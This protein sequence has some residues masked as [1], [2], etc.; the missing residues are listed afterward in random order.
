MW[1]KI[2]LRYKIYIILTTLIFITIMGGLVLIWYTFK[3]EKILSNI[4]D[5]NIVAF[6]VAESLETA[7]VN[8]KGFVSY[9]YLDGNPNW[10]RQ[11]GKYRQ[12]FK[13]Q[14]EKSHQLAEGKEQREV[15]KKIELEYYAYITAKDQ[16]IDFYMAGE[17]DK[18]VKLHQEVRDR[19]FEVLS[20]CENYK[21][22]YTDRIAQEKEQSKLHAKRIRIIGI[23]AIGVVV[24]LGVFLA[25]ILVN[26]ILNPLHRLAQEIH[27]ENEIN[28]SNNEIS[29]LSRSVKGLIKDFGEKTHRARKKSGTSASVGKNGHGR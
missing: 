8:Q 29:T 12:I 25:F 21:K 20:Q 26:H 5:K 28:A 15:I 16:V 17:K 9:Y 6:K 23:A 19:F 27:S 22:I 2:H 10:L 18:G 7:L 1:A 3:I 11:L 13:E 4:V 14:L 24:L